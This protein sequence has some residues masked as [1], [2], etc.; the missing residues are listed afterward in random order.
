MSKGGA[1]HLILWEIRKSSLVDGASLV[2]GILTNARRVHNTVDRQAVRGAKLPK[3]QFY[4][5]YKPRLGGNEHVGATI[6]RL[7]EPNTETT[8]QIRGNKRS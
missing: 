7:D 6:S 2:Q 1:H 8:Q 4:A 5:L 3:V